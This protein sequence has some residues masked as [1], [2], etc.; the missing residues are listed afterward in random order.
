MSIAA[1]ITAVFL[2]FFSLSIW[3]KLILLIIGAWL[4]MLNDWLD[5]KVTG[6]FAHRNWVTH[7]FLS[8][9]LIGVGVIGWIIGILVYPPGAGWFILWVILIFESHNG[10]NALTPTGVYSK[11]RQKMKGSIRYDS[12]GANFVLSVVGIVVVCIVILV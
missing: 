9:L 7:N 6:G 3:I 11:G 8:P 5:F 12:V 2:L 1:A 10:L 4:G